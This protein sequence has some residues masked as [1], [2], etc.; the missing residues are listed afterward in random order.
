MNVLQ[1]SNYSAKETTLACGLAGVQ[2]RH[3]PST[4]DVSLYGAQAHSF[5]CRDT[6]HLFQNPAADFSGL[7]AIRGGIPVVWPQFG[8]QTIEGLPKLP[9]H[10]L[11]RVCTWKL[12]GTEASTANGASAIFHLRGFPTHDDAPKLVRT[13]NQHFLLELEVRL[14]EKTLTHRLTICNNS[15]IRM[16][17]KSVALF[18][19]YFA[20][21]DVTHARIEGLLGATK[22]D[23]LTNLTELE[24]L[25]AKRLTARTD[26]IFKNVAGAVVL[27]QGDQPHIK[28]SSDG[29]LPD[30]VV[31]TPWSK[32]DPTYDA[33]G[34]GYPADLREDAW[35][36]FCCLEPGAVSKVLI[37]EQ[38]AQRTFTQ[39]IESLA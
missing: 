14:R 26:Q 39:V 6:E 25:N 29:T 2:L 28:V 4:A 20:V 15:P 1:T 36:T 5:R 7:G 27:F 17:L 23:R 19:N 37:L 9:L 32:S 13:F 18:H 35:R 33:K 10:G 3:G 22:V 8:T 16:P 24:S 12:V 34:A 30:V 38:G 21:Q 31:W 11:A